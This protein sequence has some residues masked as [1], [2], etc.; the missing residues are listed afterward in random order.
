MKTAI[1]ILVIILL[2]VLA[3]LTVILFAIEISHTWYCFFYEHKDWKQWEEI[4]KLLPSSSLIIHHVFEGK[5]SLLNCYAF[6]IPFL[7]SVKC[8]VDIYYWETKNTVSVHLDDGK[9]YL[10]GFDTYHVK[11]ALEI[12][13]NKLENK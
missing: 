12:I 7:D 6:E 11:K 5:N 9:C 13:K 4:C 2:I 8:T 3:I 10:S 1:L